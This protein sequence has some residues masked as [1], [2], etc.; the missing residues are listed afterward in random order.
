MIARSSNHFL[1]NII[2]LS[3]KKRTNKKERTG[4]ML[5]KWSLKSKSLLLKTGLAL[6]VISLASAVIIGSMIGFAENSAEK[7]GQLFPANKQLFDNDYSKIYDQNGNLNPELTI[8]NA[9]KTAQTGRISSDAT[10]FWFLD[11]PNQKYDFD[12]F[13]SEYY[14]RFNEPFVLEIKYG[15]FSFF[16]EYVLAVRPKQFLEFTNWF[17]TNVAWGPDLLTL[18]SFRL[19]PGV[20]QN[21]NAITLGSHSTLHKEVSEIKFFPDAFFGSLPIHSTI[22]GPGNEV[23]SLT[24]SVFSN[25]TSK[26]DLD[27]FLKNIPLA[28]ALKNDI[29]RE[30]NSDSTVGFGEIYRASKLVNKT[31]KIAIGSPTTDQ[32]NRNA[33]PVYRSPII[34]NE[35]FTQTDLDELKTQYPALNSQTLDLFKTYQIKSVKVTAPTQNNTEPALDLTVAEP[36]SETILNLNVDLNSLNNSRYV[37][38]KTL[39]SAYQDNISNYLN[40]YDMDSYLNNEFYLYQDDNKLN[41][42][43]NLFVEAINENPDLKA[44]SSLEEQQAKV[45]KYKVVSFEK[46]NNAQAQEYSLKVNLQEVLE[47]LQE[48]ASSSLEF[49]ANKANDYSPE[50]FDDFLEAINYQGGIDPVSLFYTPT[51]NQARDE[52]GNPLTGLDSRS[53][54]LYVSV[55]NNLI[56]KVVK[57]YPH[58]LRQLDGPNVQRTVDSNGV[59]QYQV[60]EGPFKGF[61]PSDR[62]GLPTVLAALVPGFDGLPI[63][64]LKYVATHEYGH[65]YTLDQG[66]AFIDRDNPV[67]VGGLS[68]RNGASEASFFSYRALINYL[69]ARSNL[70]VVRVNANNQIT[71]SGKFIRFRFGIL[72]ENGNVLRYETEPL[73][74]IWGTADANDSLS[75]VLRNKKRRFLQDFSGL[76]EAAKLRNVAIR[77]LFFANSF[78]SDSGTI[79]PSISG[80]AK[81]FVKSETEGGTSEYKWAPV[82]A[83][84]IISQ[85]TDGAGNPLL[86]RS[87]FVSPND[88]LSFRIFETDPNKSNVITKINMFNK[89]GSPVIQVPL[90]VELSPAELAYVQRQAKVISDSISATIN[91]NLADNGWDSAGTV[92]GGEISASVG[93]AIES[94]GVSALVEKIKTRSQPSELSP[95]A[96]RYDEKSRKGFSYFA[97]ENSL[98]LQLDTLINNYLS[99]SNID[100]E[101]RAGSRQGTSASYIR[102][103][104]NKIVAVKKTTGSQKQFSDF[105]TYVFPFVRGNKFLGEISNADDDG[106]IKGINGIA[107]NNQL[108]TTQGLY[109]LNFTHTILTALGLFDTPQARNSLISYATK[110]SMQNGTATQSSYV[111]EGAIDFYKKI[112]EA[113]RSATGMSNA[114]KAATGIAKIDDENVLVVNPF[115]SGLSALDHSLLGSL[116]TNKKIEVKATSASTQTMS[117]FNSKNLSE[118]L[119]F[120]SLDYSKATYDAQTKRYNWDVAYA[121]SKFDLNSIEKLPAPNLPAAATLKAAI[122]AASTNTTA[123]NQALANYAIYLFRHSNLFMSVKDFSP[124]TDLVKNRA[125]FSQLYGVTMLDRNFTRYYVEDLTPE[126]DD[127]VNFDTKRLQAFFAKF[128]KDNK[129]EAV[130]SQLSFHDLLLLTGNIV[131]YANNGNVGLT[132]GSFI[133]GYFSPGLSSDDVINYNATRVEPLLADKFTDYVYN[134]AET[135]TRDYVQTTYAPNTKDFENVPNF[136]GGL[137][138]AMSGLDYI[139]DATNI[140]KVND[141]RTSQT[142]LAKALQTIYLGP[143]YT[144]F[145]DELI[146]I[147]PDAVTK[148]NDAVYEFFAASDEMT[149]VRQATPNDTN[150]IAEALA[151]QIVARQKVTDA[152]KVLDELKAKARGMFFKN[153]DNNF[154]QTNERRTSSY[155]GQFISKNNGYFK[156]HFEKLTIG[157]ELYD[158]NLNPVIDNNIRTVDFNGNKVNKRPEAFFLSQ[159]YNYGVSKRTVSGLFRNQNLD[160]LALYGYVPTELASKIGYLRF[161]NV[162]TNQAVYLKV[163]TQR[164]NN[165]FWL[166]KQGDPNSKRTIEDYGYT[167]WLSDYALMGKY[168]DALL[169]P[170]NAYTVD[171]VDK[172]HNFLQTV[173][174]GDVQYISENA[175]SVEQSPV[176]IENQNTTVDGNKRIKTV[177]S[178]DFQFNV[179]N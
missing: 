94:E 32:Q 10:E 50:G 66:Q 132:L 53:Y 23:D 17:I 178:I 63:D 162:L 140:N 14:K 65:H 35:N 3:Q 110:P 41:H 166:Q 146:K 81:A 58:L 59:F 51:D 60:V 61:T 113:L 156:D 174:L 155:F 34:V 102:S 104:A 25:E 149:R 52:Q 95:F 168:R 97:L 5:K 8:T 29:Q 48:G 18:D 69:D 70:E 26:K 100:T 9:N 108:R 12:Q 137:S 67:I 1:I 147:Q 13:F 130:Q 157:A 167:S 96:N 80:L 72:D 42:F 119:S 77:D 175:K 57:K 134:I 16:D 159:L 44:L 136:L 118:L 154:F 170:G 164:T 109:N 122:T 38:Y 43:Y 78:D 7:N 75:E 141:T 76:T 139:V 106:L 37:S 144:A 28:S 62:I 128:V 169:R 98:S 120:V 103:D 117:T 88:Q 27:Q 33:P 112:A 123:Q 138:E 11:N 90:N 171:F 124:A 84:S 20:E 105:D 56:K 85:L 133:F 24:Y 153:N 158:E 127:G 99:F 49:V 82:T 142:D 107:S 165:I 161:T 46:T 115:G 160:A 152:Q 101:Q 4:S 30:G 148:F 89:D 129:L 36:G 15:S 177:I 73:E 143:K 121:Q 45:K 126:L 22:A 131:Y 19:V 68:T 47:N 79:N 83:A 55:Y 125:V 71:P 21:G 176:K 31:F 39:L 150:A 173:D 86:N 145:Y 64:F 163:N 93:S 116:P 54:Q 87:V 135:L 151:K 172:D 74:D 91:K 179:T 6:G 40:F 111:L 92:L 114:D 2:N